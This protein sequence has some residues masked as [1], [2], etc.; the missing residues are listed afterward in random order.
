MEVV[1]YTDASHDNSSKIAACGFIVLKDGQLKKHEIAIVGNLLRS[2]DSE[3]YSVIHSLEYAF[4]I[5]G[6]SKIIVYTDHQPITIKGAKIKGAAYVRLRQ[7]INIIK[8]YKVRV[9]LT[10]IKGHTNNKWNTLVDVECRMALRKHLGKK[11]PEQSP[12]FGYYDN[13]H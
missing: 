10:H 3:I 12:I 7:T 5:D 8:E 11:I 6:V 2:S 13:W 1:V 9:V 4:L